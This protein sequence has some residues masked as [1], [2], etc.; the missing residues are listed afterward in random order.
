M[1]QVTTA[2]HPK[3]FRVSN[4]ELLLNDVVTIISVNDVL[5]VVTYQI[6]ISL[7]PEYPDDDR[8]FYELVETCVI[9]FFFWGKTVSYRKIK[10]Y[11]PEEMNDQELLTRDLLDLIERIR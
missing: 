1:I 9:L 8:F 10:Q 3:S 2:H 5:T 11:S 6:K 4:P 7:N